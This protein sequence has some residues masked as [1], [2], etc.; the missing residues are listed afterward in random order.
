MIWLVI[1]SPEERQPSN[2]P[3]KCRPKNMGE[4]NDGSYGVYNTGSQI[5]F[6]SAI[7]RSSLCDYSDTYILVKGTMIVE[8]IGTAAAPNNRNKKVIFKNCTPFTE[9]ISEIKS[10]E[11]D[12]DKG[13][14]AVMLTY[15]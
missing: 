5:K 15:N 12:Y 11:I 6:K 1:K 9:F 2:Q 13:I 8:N 4:I 3:S 7:L 14:D 10:K